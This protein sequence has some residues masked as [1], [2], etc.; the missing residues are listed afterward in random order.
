MSRRYVASS[1]PESGARLMNSRELPF[2][3]LNLIHTS[4][5]PQGSARGAQHSLIGLNT[6]TLTLFK[7]NKREMVKKSRDYFL[8]LKCSY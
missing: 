6:L 8:C 4:L 3:F 5:H 7:K 2:L 1:G